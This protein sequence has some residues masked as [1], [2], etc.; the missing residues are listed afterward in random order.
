MQGSMHRFWEKDAQPMTPL[1]SQ[2]L[3]DVIGTVA[4]SDI[5]VRIGDYMFR[6]HQKWTITAVP[7]AGGYLGW[8]LL[9][10]CD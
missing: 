4:E 8:L 2:T 7:E 9:Q 6:P 10:D 5:N 1:K 3:E